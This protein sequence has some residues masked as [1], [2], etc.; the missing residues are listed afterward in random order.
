MKRL[1]ATIAALVLLCLA[2]YAATRGT[3]AEAKAMLQKAVDHYKSV[4]RK[5]ALSD[6]SGG[7]APFH[8]RDLYVVCIASDHKVLANG[9]FPA[10]VGISADTLLDAKGQA[11]GKSFWDAASKAP[12]GS[13]DYPMINPVTKKMESKTM[14]YSRVA[15]D[16]L[17]GVGAYSAH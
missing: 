14:F 9:G 17:C 3:P 15:D 5:Q 7:K 10:Y 4:G 16:L 13:V 2:A 11:L 8:D 1:V 6:F 12:L